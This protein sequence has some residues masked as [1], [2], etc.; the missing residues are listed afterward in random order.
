MKTMTE[1][2]SCEN[3][4]KVT[5]EELS[6]T[7]NELQQTTAALARESAARAMLQEKLDATVEVKPITNR[8]PFSPF[9]IDMLAVNALQ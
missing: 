5:R 3:E 7:Q 9:I 6:R 8:T 2:T 4:N 1:L